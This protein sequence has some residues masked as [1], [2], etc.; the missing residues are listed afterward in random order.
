MRELK[1]IIALL[2]LAIGSSVGRK[3]LIDNVDMVN[4][5]QM[6]EYDT[7]FADCCMKEVGC[8]LIVVDKEWYKARLVANGCTQQVGIDCDDTFS[9]V[10]KPATIR[11][12]L[13]LSLSRKW[14]V[15]QLAVKNAFLNGYILETVYII[16]DSSLFIYRHGIE[17]ACL[18]IYVDDIVLTTSS[19]ALLQRIISFLHQEFEMTDLGALNYF[20]GILVTRDST[21]D[22]ESKLGP[23]GDHVSDPTLHN[24]L[25]QLF[26]SSTGSLI[27]YSDA[28][29]VG[30][31]STG[32]VYFWSS[33]EAEYQ[34]VANDVAETAWIQN[35]L[36]E[37][38]TPLLFA[39]PLY[40]YNVSAIYL[41][42]NLVQHQRTKHIEIDIHFVP[43]KVTKVQVRVLH[44]T[45]RYQYADIFTNG[46]PLALFEEL[47][48][49]LSVHS[50]LGLTVGEC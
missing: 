34:G 15:Q 9:P 41:S 3:Y 49:S 2:R 37:L 39:T 20:L 36:W 30:C 26:A 47:R 29:W 11:A 7:V 23:D 43:D 44:V 21:V 48:T 12:V 19:T 14:L 25:E 16:Y 1:K 18:L 6:V 10:V 38:H 22:A 24:N 4:K 42:A 17:V 27:S 13:S 8:S 5:L 31:P 33:A 35:L 32:S 28:D 50:S 45:S 46:L 40:C